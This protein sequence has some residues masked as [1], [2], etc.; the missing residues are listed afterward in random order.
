MMKYKEFKDWC[1][2][3]ACDGRWG[4][5]IAI[6][7]ISIMKYINSYPFWKREKEWMKIS[8]EVEREIIN[9]INQKIEEYKS[10][11]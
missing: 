5:N 11:D 8:E 4:P 10:K 6:I 1:N 2:E 9:P 7:C 3:R